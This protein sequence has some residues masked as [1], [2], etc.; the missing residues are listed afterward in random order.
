MFLGFSDVA[1]VSSAITGADVTVS[2]HTNAI[3]AKA[4]IF[5][6]VNKIETG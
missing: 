4:M 3:K 5:A 1:V 2:M 6:T